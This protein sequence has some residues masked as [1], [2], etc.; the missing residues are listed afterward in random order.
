MP[1][2]QPLTVP[3]PSFAKLIFAICIIGLAGFVLWQQVKGLDTF[4]VKKAFGDIGILQWIG[5]AVAT[6]GSFYAL[7]H[8]DALCH[9][10]LRTQVSQQHAHRTGMCAVAIGQTIGFASLTGGLVRWHRLRGLAPAQVIAVSAAVSVSFMVCWTLLAIPALWWMMDG[11]GFDVPHFGVVG[12]IIA[13]IGFYGARLAA[14]RDI[15]LR[16]AVRMLFWTCADLTF[17]ALVIAVLLPTEVAFA[18]VLAAVIIATGAG[19]LSNAPG[20]IGAFDLTLMALLPMVPIETLVSVLLAYR[21]IYILIPFTIAAIAVARPKQSPDQHNGLGPAPWGLARQTGM[22]VQQ[23]GWRA[24]LGETAIGRVAIGDPVGP[25]TAWSGDLHAIYKCS[26]RTAATLRSLGW[27][28][29][30]IATEARLNPQH[31]ALTG[32]KR[33]SLRRKLRKAQTEG[34]TIREGHPR[35]AEVTTIAKAWARN[36]GGELGFSMGRFD[37]N[38]I[39]DQRIF[40][41][42]QHGWTIGFVTFHQ[43][44]GS[45]ALDLIRYGRDLPTGALQAAVVAALN[46]AKAEG[47][48]RFCLGAVPSFDG[49]LQ[50]FD[51]ARAGLVQ[52]KRSF[53]PT[54]HPVYHAARSPLWFGLSAVAVFW[55]IQRPVANLRYKA[56]VIKVMHGFQLRRARARV[57][58]SGHQTGLPCD[59]KSVDETA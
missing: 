28:T 35:K 7:G 45:W 11:T 16:T 52:F 13:V 59:D 26:D 38:Y 30:R 25:Q 56:D 58:A 22:V 23:N 34:I 10:M 24:H 29:T 6:W 57:I 12:A 47:A 51:Q 44:G 17:A 32:S 4:A 3:K 21:L 31:F 41:I 54:W 1:V 27:T 43:S 20:G 42:I 5:A 40:L 36:H 53:G 48:T 39:K 15:P 9:R 14:A 2:R 33:Q 19:L 55:A 18:T 46:S 37:L 49:R 8:Y 50:R